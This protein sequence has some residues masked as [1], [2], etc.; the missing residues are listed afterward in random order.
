[1]EI[2]EKQFSLFLFYLAGKI[3]PELAS[4]PVFLYSVCGTLPQ[5]G[6]MSRV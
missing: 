6:L 2:S 4:V 1:M 5:H 3:V